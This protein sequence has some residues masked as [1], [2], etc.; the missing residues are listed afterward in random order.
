MCSE[1]A[2]NNTL[3]FV[4]PE[5]AAQPTLADMARFIKALN[6]DHLTMETVFKISD[7]KS[8]F[9]RFKNK[10]AM[11]YS[12]EHNVDMLPFHYSNGNKVMVRMTVAGENTRYVR[13]FDLPPEISDQD[14]MSVMSK[15][16]KVRRTVRERFPAEYQLDI[17]TGVRGLYMDVERDIPEVLYFCHRK[18]RIFYD[19]I[20]TRCFVCKSDAHLKKSCPILQQRQSE[21]IHQPQEPKRD[22]VNSEGGNDVEATIKMDVVDCE[23]KNNQRAKRKSKKS[24]TK[25]QRLVDSAVDNRLQKEQHNDIPLSSESDGSLIN[26]ADPPGRKRRFRVPSYEWIKDDNERQLLLQDDMKRIAATYN[27]SEEMIG[28][29]HDSAP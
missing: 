29:F 3:A 23:A 2:V 22:V 18:G 26:V 12:L 10:E 4:F 27:I 21:N 14:V 11:K 9:I 15:F 19:G 7:Q 28:I 24:E 16:G 5:N 17:F 20:K 8:V 13:V 6:S 25:R 1:A